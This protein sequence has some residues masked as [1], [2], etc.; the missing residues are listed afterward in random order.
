MS[1]LVSGRRLRV[2]LILNEVKVI[3][4]NLFC[5]NHFVEIIPFYRG[6]I[7]KCI[8]YVIYEYILGSE[9]NID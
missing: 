6:R 8:H 1:G 7:Y 4:M 5:I 3:V 9:G 2:L